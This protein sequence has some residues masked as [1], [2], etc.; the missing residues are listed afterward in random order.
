V[1]FQLSECPSMLPAVGEASFL[2][3]H[4]TSEGWISNNKRVFRELSG[5]ETLL[6][7]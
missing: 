2:Y 7:G 1:R 3:S 6:N 4:G 5:R